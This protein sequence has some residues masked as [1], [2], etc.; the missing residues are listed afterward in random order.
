MELGEQIKSLGISLLYKP[1]DNNIR[2][3][4]FCKNG[5]WHIVINNNDMT[6]RQNFTIAHELFEIHLYND[7][8]LTTMEKHMQAN[9]YAAELLLPESEFKAAV[10]SYNLF[11]LKELFP[12]ASHE[13][14]ARR[15][16]KFIPAVVTILD[17]KNIT[18][19]FASS[20]INYPSA[21]SKEEINVIERCYE[22]EILIEVATDTFE[23]NGYFL[24]E[25]N[26]IKRVITI[27]ELN[28]IAVI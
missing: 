24:N 28:E 1:L 12:E 8:T 13:V 3:N 7:S 16:I 9:E 19:R 23:M 14:I 4:S 26:G 17:N 15:L 25:M 11:E 2:G 22:R 10:H 21:P 20:G 5:V 6:E 18:S 27:L